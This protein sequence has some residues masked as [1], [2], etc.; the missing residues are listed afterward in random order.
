MRCPK[1][2]G[3]LHAEPDAIRCL[4]CG[5]HLYEPDPPEA[6]TMD[7]ARWQSVLCAKCSEVPAIYNKELCPKCQDARHQRQGYGHK[8][9]VEKN[10]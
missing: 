2:S 8:K 6:L 4:N 5:M 9:I 10:A 7:P 1:C 3:C